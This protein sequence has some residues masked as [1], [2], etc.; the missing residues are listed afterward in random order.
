LSNVPSLD[1]WGNR[2]TNIA[3]V[4]GMTQLNWLGISRNNLYVIQPLTGLPNLATIDASVNQLTNVAGVSGL[5]SL[6]N[7]ILSQNS[8]TVI[9]PLTGLPN[10]T[11]LDLHTN[12]LT[13][14]SGLA[15]LTS[16]NWLYL[17]GNDLQV[18]HALTNLT[19]LNYADLTYNLLNTNLLSPAMLDIGVMQA[20]NTY[21]NYIPQKTTSS[22]SVL[23]LSPASLGG[24]KF[25]FTLQSVP[26][27]VLQVLSST[28][29][30]NWTPLGSL[31]TNVTGMTLYTDSLAT[32]RQKLYRAQTQ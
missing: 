7:L 22:G 23:L 24:N 8:L 12:Y 16:L 17:N 18:I 15:G 6:G 20:H 14:V 10:L 3:G 5:P 26:G 32:A 2:L 1:F 27:A 25:R 21:V 9:Q 13:D 28:N 19:S 11:S 31:V 30:A 4:S 29:F